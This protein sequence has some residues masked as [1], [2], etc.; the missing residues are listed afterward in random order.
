[1]PMKEYEKDL[2][3][4]TA[5]SLFHRRKIEELNLNICIQQIGSMFTLFFGKKRVANLKEAMEVNKEQFIHFF[6]TLFKQGIYIPPSPYES[7]CV[8]SVHTKEH[9]FY[10]SEKVVEFLETIA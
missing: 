10:T 2:S 7:W 5:K 8:S 1:M 4:A 6:Q 3:R 9:L